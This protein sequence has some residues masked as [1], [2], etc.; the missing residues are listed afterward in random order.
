MPC[1]ACSAT[2]TPG[3]RAA[4]MRQPA[5]G[6]SRSRRRSERGKAAHGEADEVGDATVRAPAD[7]GGDTLSLCGDGARRKGR[8][9]GVSGEV[10]HEEVVGA[11]VR[12]D[13]LPF[14]VR[15]AEA[16]Q[17]DDRVG[18]GVV[19][20]EVPELVCVWGCCCC[21][22]CCCCIAASPCEGVSAFLASLMT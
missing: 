11:E 4:H 13:E 5:K 15:A 20:R 3:Y 8:R 9:G 18:L 7:Q 22:C 19:E 6:R 17:E 10:R 1:A 14:E 2:S 21:C 12:P 16:V